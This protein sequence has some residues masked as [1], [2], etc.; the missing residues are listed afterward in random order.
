MKY[1]FYIIF[2]FIKYNFKKNGKKRY[3][4]LYKYIIKNKPIN[5]CEIGIYTGERSEEI[6]KL[7][8]LSSRQKINFVGFD[9]FDE[10]DDKKIQQE[11]S[12]QPLNKRIIEK[13][14]NKLSFLNSMKL[15]Q[16]DTNFTLPKISEKYNKYFD[17]I[18]IDGGHSIETINSD[19]QNCIKLIK[20][21][22]IIILDDFY[23]NNSELSKIAGCNELV[24]NIDNKKY[25]VEILSK[26]DTHNSKYG[27][28]SISLVKVQNNI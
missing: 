19:F 12:K 28:F 7:S 14:L 9:L 17:F 27:L 2:L 20:D 6:I 15:I 25:N 24:K 3:F 8:H 10:I 21:D 13:K 18:F 22:G 11:F 23:Y 26:R 1:I 16:G 4:D 5:I